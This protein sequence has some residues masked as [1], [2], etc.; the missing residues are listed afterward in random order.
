MLRIEDWKKN[1]NDTWLL[2]AA[3][4]MKIIAMICKKKG[5][6]PLK[7][8]HICYFLENIIKYFIKSLKISKIIKPSK[9]YYWVCQHS[10]DSLFLIDYLMS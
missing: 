5:K 9:K 6:R 3:Q 2:C 1:Q 4:N 8:G 10:E 7:R